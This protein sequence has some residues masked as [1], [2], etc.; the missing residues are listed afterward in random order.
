[1]IAEEKALTFAADLIQ[2]VWALELLIVLK[3]DPAR[4]WSADEL[5]RELRGS[6]VVVADALNNLRA[7]GLAVENGGSRYRYHPVSPVMDEL[8]SEL[9]KLYALKPTTVTRAIVTSP[10]RKLQ[11]LSDA[12]RIKE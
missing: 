7:A 11:M 9:V 10:N 2:S 6:Q 8:V 3:R 12:F 5:I 4:Y 1:M